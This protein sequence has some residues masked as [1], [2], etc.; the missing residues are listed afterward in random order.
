MHGKV[1]ELRSPPHG[2]GVR[3]E[4]DHR[5]LT[6]GVIQLRRAAEIDLLVLRV[7]NDD[8][9]R[10]G[11]PKRFVHVLESFR[12]QD[13][14]ARHA[15]RRGSDELQRRA[16]GDVVRIGDGAVKII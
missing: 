16:V 2:F 13:G 4:R 9:T 3:H 11:S 8:E 6:V 14:P 7:G 10:I 1:R 15:I 5:L 12:A